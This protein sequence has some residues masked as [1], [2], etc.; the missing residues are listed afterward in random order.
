MFSDYIES[1]ARTLDGLRSFIDLVQP[2]LD[3]KGRE[4]RKRGAGNLAPLILGFAQ[5]NPSLL[6]KLG[7]TESQLRKTFD[8]DIKIKKGK[9]GEEP[10]FS[11]SVSGPQSRAFDES[12]IEI[13]R[14]SQRISLLYQN[15]LISLISA[16][17]C[18]LSQIIHKYYYVVPDALSNKDKVLSFDD[19]KN[20]GSVEDARTYLIEN[21]VEE[22]MR[23]SFKDWISF[24]RTQANLS[25]S[26]LE[27]YMD[28]LVET[29]ERRNLLV[30][31]AGIVNTIYISKVSAELRKGIKK[32][33]KI[34]L[35]R[36]Y[37]DESI[38]YF[39][40]YSILIAAELWK[41]LKPNDDKRA[42][43]L[44]DISYNHLRIY[45]WTVSEGLSYFMMMDKKAKEPFQLNGT[46]NYWQS[47]KRQ[48]RWDEVKEAATSEDFSAKG[49]RYQLG[50]L[51]LLEKKKEFF[52]LVP[53]AL[54]GEEITLEELREFPIFV[55]MRKDRRFSKY[56]KKKKPLE[57][58]SKVMG[59]TTKKL[60]KAK[61]TSTG[62]KPKSRA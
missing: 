57:A 30:H 21:K 58:K 38:D 29:C 27:P 43:I 62:R 46:L 31:N 56:K 53:I 8:G 50:Q 34:R 3:K 15:S 17:E 39:E 23:K 26:Y 22:L 24:F 37:L 9:G 25:M 1:F 14:A 18:F 35:T 59:K 13:T 54:S 16:V 61:K 6:K 10:L 12:M 42:E 44:G 5:D 51:A 11:I 28:K 60:R 4:A 2:F 33:K 49:I 36:K 47:I 55:D 7:L 20:F 32:G 48:G 41:K 40:L 19:L 52:D 45:R